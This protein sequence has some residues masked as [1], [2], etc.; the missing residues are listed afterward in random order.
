MDGLLRDLREELA[1]T[2]QDPLWHGEGDVL[3][4]T[5]MVCRAL[6]GLEAYRAA[7]RSVQELLYLAA[8]LHDVG[9]LRTTR[10]E[11]GR[12][13]APGHGRVGAFMVRRILWQQRG[14]CGGLRERA[15]RES[16]CGLIRYHTLPL[17]AFD[18]PDGRL[19]LLRFASNGALAPGMTV[20]NLC[21]LARAD[22]LGRLC[23]DREDLLERIDL[24]E[25]L[26]REIGCLTGPYPFPSDHTAYAVLSG[27][28]VPPDHP[29][30]DDT[31]GTVIL[32][33]GLP[34]T[35]KDTWIGQNCPGLPMVSLD[36]LRKELGVPPA[37]DQRPVVEAAT[38]RARELLRQKIPFVWNATDLTPMTRG[39]QIRLFTEYGASVR[40]VYLE[41]GEEERRRRNRERPDAVPEDAVEHMLDILSPPERWEAHRVEWH[42]V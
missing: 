25:E 3:C 20:Q 41:T 37:D 1:R 27:R 6:C 2:P 18:E 8:L 9:K 40:A 10:R 14:L 31:W 4:H 35:G 39:R 28:N 32:M 29:L 23:P 7:H 36:A 24:C 11:D 22:V 19:R 17:H 16:V 12:W 30:Y 42:T 21:T 33:S 34:G 5:Q 13:T 15:L 38:R 26:A